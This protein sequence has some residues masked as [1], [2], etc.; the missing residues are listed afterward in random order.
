MMI[1][2]RSR[3]P[4]LSKGAPAQNLLIKSVV[5]PWVHY[6]KNA[7]EMS[8]VGPSSPHDVTKGTHSLHEKGVQTCWSPAAI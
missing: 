3:E 4:R 7:K 8:M 5:Q 6:L 2:A 1:P